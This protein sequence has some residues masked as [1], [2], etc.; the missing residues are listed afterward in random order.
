MKQI[1]SIIALLPSK[2]VNDSLELIIQN[3]INLGQWLKCEL[4]F[5]CPPDEEKAVKNLV[6]EFVKSCP[7]PSST[8]IVHPPTS[9]NAESIITTIQKYDCDMILLQNNIRYPGGNREDLRIIELSPIPILLLPKDF[10]FKANPLDTFLVPL[11]GK[12]HINEA[13]ALSLKLASVTGS[14]VDLLHVT[15]KEQLLCSC[16]HS[17]D[18]LGDQFHHE[19]CQIIDKITSEQSPYSSAIEKKRIRHFYQR[20]GF[21]AEEILHILKE[22]PGKILVLEWKET[23]AEKYAETVKSLL[24][25]MFYPVIFIRTKHEEN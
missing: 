8:L 1:K 3:A 18:S 4:H 7:D 10:D 9:G 17:L 13:L 5:L 15:S 19:Y 6:C 12:K 21:V 16:R 20:Q 23:L 25:N 11:S 2:L 24:E 22:S 14:S